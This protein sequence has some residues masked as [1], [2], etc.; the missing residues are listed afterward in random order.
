MDKFSIDPSY[1]NQ[2]VSLFGNLTT[3]EKRRQDSLR[4]F[5]QLDIAKFWF[6]PWFHFLIAQYQ[7]L[8]VSYVII[9][10]L[11]I[12]IM[13]ATYVVVHREKEKAEKERNIDQ[14]WSL[15]PVSRRSDLRLSQ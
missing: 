1:L 12:V 3:H 15:Q 11:T 4:Q 10:L 8:A 14:R 5:Y 7:Y 13:S 9:I 6:L 2:T